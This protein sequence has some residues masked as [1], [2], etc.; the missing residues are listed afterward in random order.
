MVSKSKK[1]LRAEICIEA[2]ALDTNHSSE[3]E[4]QIGFH[5]EIH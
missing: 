4:G 3:S 1:T 5:E 2:I